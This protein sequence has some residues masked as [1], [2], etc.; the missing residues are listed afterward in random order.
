MATQV[1][2]LNSFLLH[3]PGELTTVL[4][5][6]PV[7]PTPD[8]ISLPRT[9]TTTIRNPDAGF[10]W[11]SGTPWWMSSLTR[12]ARLI[13][14][15]SSSCVTTDEQ[16]RSSRACTPTWSFTRVF[17]GNSSVIGRR[18]CKRDLVGFNLAPSASKGRSNSH[19]RHCIRPDALSHVDGLVG[20]EGPSVRRQEHL[21]EL[22]PVWDEPPVH[23]GGAP[24]RAVNGRRRPAMTLTLDESAV[25]S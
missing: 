7:E 4:I 19:R 12:N 22:T 5:R 17:G 20:S 25:F 24:R 2:W 23:L 9:C 11:L 18:T 8:R 13:G 15:Y 21:T 1:L 14:E 6:H 16:D 3:Q 10:A